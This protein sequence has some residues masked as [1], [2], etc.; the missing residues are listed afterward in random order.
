MEPEIKD[1]VNNCLDKTHNE[2]SFDLIDAI[3]KPLPA[4]VIAK[5]MGLPKEDLN[6]LNGLDGS[7]YLHKEEASLYDKSDLRLNWGKFN[8]SKRDQYTGIPPNFDEKLKNGLNVEFSKR[9]T[10]NKDSFE[11][12]FFIDSLKILFDKSL[13]IAVLIDTDW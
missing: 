9:S 12:I 3:A 4:M 7:N 10:K 13:D 2:T 6:D 8:I 11:W 5:M 1:T